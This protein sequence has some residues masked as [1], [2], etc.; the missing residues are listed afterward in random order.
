MIDG[1]I[2]G[3]ECNNRAGDGGGFIRFVHGEGQV[4]E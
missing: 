1:L 4:E 2:D 3:N